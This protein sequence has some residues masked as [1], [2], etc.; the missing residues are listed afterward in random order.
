MRVA[1]VAVV[2]P[3]RSAKSPNAKPTPRTIAGARTGN[4]DGPGAWFGPHS[5]LSASPCAWPARFIARTQ[6]LPSIRFQPRVC[7]QTARPFA[8][9][10]DCLCSSR[11]FRLPGKVAC[12]CSRTTGRRL[13]IKPI[14]PA[15]R[16]C[17]FG[18]GLVSCA[19]SL[20]YPVLRAANVA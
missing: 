4:L 19:P 11:Q 17:L 12:S 1:V 7:E 5:P 3:G 10:S 20:V 8:G 15:S 16:R 13:L 18:A 14:P 6:C 9:A 2:V